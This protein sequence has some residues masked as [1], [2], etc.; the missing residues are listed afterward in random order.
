MGSDRPFE[1]RDT[2]GVVLEGPLGQGRA[3]QRI[4]RFPTDLFYLVRAMGQKSNEAHI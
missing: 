2:F 1:K 4:L 3:S